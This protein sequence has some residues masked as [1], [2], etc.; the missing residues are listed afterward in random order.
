MKVGK[1]YFIDKMRKVKRLVFC[2][3][4]ILGELL[5]FPKIY[6]QEVSVLDKMFPNAIISREHY[7]RLQ[8][9]LSKEGE[10]D[11]KVMFD[12]HIRRYAEIV[13]VSAKQPVTAISSNNN[14]QGVDIYEEMKSIYY[15][16][17]T[18]AFNQDQRY[19][20]KAVDYLTA[21]ARV[22]VAEPKSNI[23]EEKY[24][25]AVEGYSLI[26]NIISIEERQLIDEWMK[27]RLNQFEKDNDLRGNNWGA[28]LLR[29]YY[30]YGL[31]LGEDK[32]INKYKDA[33]PEWVKG[34]LFPNGTTTD[35]LAR[36]AFAYHAYDLSFF[37][38]IAHLIALYDGY[39]AADRFYT[40]EINGGASVKKCVDFWKPFILDS[41]KYRH[42]EFVDTEYE[43]DKKREDYNK[44]YNPSST[45]YVIDEL[46]EFDDSL[47][48]I[49]DKYWRGNVWINW[50][51]SLSALR[52]L[53]DGK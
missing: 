11:F 7:D 42:I 34:N 38:K 50:R 27:K 33:Y 21:W 14:A 9:E 53:N 43:P 13:M 10:N 32:W 6:A 25:W 44:V 30:L 26:R 12:K 4:M 16:C 19:L 41:P 40:Q 20:D 5:L 15:L 37:A 49:F 47:K 29:Q 51:S 24:S 1:Q 17:V 31:V 18:Y 45:L 39:D 8:T 3:S 46:Y 23:H 2:I 22:N 52:W 48:E 35:L 36:D 28:C